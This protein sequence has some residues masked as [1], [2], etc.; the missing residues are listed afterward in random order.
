M[1]NCC[2]PISGGQNNDLN[3]ND[4]GCCTPAVDSSQKKVEGTHKAYCPE[5][6]ENGKRVATIT[7][8]SMLDLFCPTA[9]CPIVYFAS[10]GMQSFTKAQIRVPVY[11]KVPDDDTVE[12]CYCFRHSP[13]SI[14]DEI[15]TTGQS[16]VIEE[17]NQAIK[18]GKCACEI[19][20]PQGTCCLGNVIAVVDQLKETLKAP[21]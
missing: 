11:R 3:S 13:S 5:C 8:K 21:A 18:A 12:V 20:N 9:D 16:T 19:R 4:G 14:H 6:N 1:A 17:I 7:L 10:V 15:M 2:T